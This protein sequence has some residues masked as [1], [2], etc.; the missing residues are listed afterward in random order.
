MLSIT[1]DILEVQ[2]DKDGIAVITLNMKNLPANVMN[3][4]SLRA[5]GEAVTLT[6]EDLKIKGAIIT[7][8]RKE[9]MAGGDLKAMLTMTDREEIFRGLLEFNAVLRKMETGGKPFVAC[10][11]GSAL[12]GGFEIPL[13]CHHRVA[14]YDPALR[15][16]LPEVKLGLLPGSGGTQRLP[17]L[18]GIEK[19]LRYILQGLTVPAEQALKDGLIHAIVSSP[20]ELL[21]AGKKY[22]KE[23]GSHV[24]P[25][26]EKRFKVPGGDVLTPHG[27][28]TFSAGAG[29]LRQE[30]RGNYPGAQ[31]AMSAI[32]EGLLLPIDRGTTVEAR[33]FVK[34]LFSPEARNIIKTGFFAINKANKGV[35]RP[36]NVPPFEVKKVGI[37]GAGLM[38]AGIAYVTAKAGMEVVLKDV[39]EEVA[40]KGKT[41]S[42]GLI[43]KDISRGKT[44]AEKGKKLLD[45]I[46]PTAN[47]QDVARCDLVIEAVF[48]NRELKAAVTSESEQV[49]A[50][51]AIFASN[52]STIPITGLAESSIR[53][54]NFIGLHFF[55]PVDKMPLVEI[56]VGE[57]TSE[58]A[59]AG[60]IDYVLKIRKTPIV[61]N[62]SR[63]FFTSR[64]FSTFTMEGIGMLTEGIP[65]A[66][67]ENASKDVGLPVGALAVSDEVNLG[68]AQKIRKQ[69]EADLGIKDTRPGALVVDK[70]VDEFGRAGK[71]QG[72]GFYEYPANGKKHLWPGLKEH[73]PERKDI[74][75]YETIKKRLLHIQAL[76]AVKCLDEGVLRS[77][78]DG[79]VGSLL[80][81][82]FPPYT[83]G[84]LSYIEYVGVGKFVAECEAFARLYGERFLPPLSLKDRI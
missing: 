50:E 63:G 76:E 10:L 55:S 12:G 20:E 30:T 39:S 71:R 41:Y 5:I 42:E 9:F 40:I 36:K 72:K 22:I 69:T 21:E 6:V 35:A 33:Y 56:I 47:P 66:M 31:Y 81:W 49:L 38:G 52:T 65:A 11:N 80:G 59:L 43:Q 75:D 53:P 78:E 24:Q 19:S 37:L 83:G 32:F 17:R 62:D 25:W 45:L 67:I 27:V 29:L 23:N 34:V 4:E 51:T 82:G 73:F 2:S 15:V 79:D 7:S 14:V 48:E 28:Q 61:V 84:V 26:D 16:G 58:Y 74:P 18:I 77:A 68:L 1:N 13:A 46:H 64:V 60:A 70:M 8:S 3:P 57:N 54:Q 44:T